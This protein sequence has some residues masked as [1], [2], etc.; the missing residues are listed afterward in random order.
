MFDV[1]G[2]PIGPLVELLR[3]HAD[4]LVT[5]GVASI[6]LLIGTALLIPLLIV[7]LPPDYFL[8]GE[9][10]R[11]QA[12]SRGTIMF[13]A[14]AVLRNL[15]GIILFVAG[16]IM[17]FVPG[18][19]LLTILI[20]LMLIDFPGKHA[21]LMRLAA[22]PHVMR[23]ANRIRRFAGKADFLQPDAHPADDG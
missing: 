4:T 10:R 2:R 19:G 11:R 14:F 15:I 9:N 21:M 3:E 6:V 22:N 20:A 23:G 8:Q 5:I 13:L 17:L 7:R 12:R 16:V 1:S 18:Q